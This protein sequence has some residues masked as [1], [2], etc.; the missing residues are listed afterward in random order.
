MKRL[1]I[2]IGILIFG[3]DSESAWNCIQ[4]TGDRVQVTI[5][6]PAFQTVVVNRDIELVITEGAN[7]E[8]IVETGENL[9]DDIRVEVVN[10][11]LR[12]TDNN[13]CNFVREYGETTIRIQAPDLTEIRNSS[14]YE[15]SS[16]G[17]L[18]YPDLVLT[19]EDFNA[20]G[21]FTVGDFR[22]QLNTDNLQIVSN[23]LSSYYLSGTVVNLNIGFFSGSGRFEGEDLIAQNVNVFHRGSNDM[24]VNP[25]LSI[26]GVIN[27]TGDVFSLNTPANVSVEELYT[28]RL[29]FLD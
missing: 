17:I 28:G 2:I 8:V 1:I 7:H 11:K 29:I 6:V 9:L 3:C 13:T 5:D 27:S 24:I 14:Q 23:N 19:A 20:P 10:G 21:S 22:M 18:N 4:S 16:N 12:L 15:I 25:Q 26:T